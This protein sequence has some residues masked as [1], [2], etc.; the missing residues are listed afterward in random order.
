MFM[1]QMNADK[2]TQHELRKTKK[3]AEE[4]TNAETQH[5][6]LIYTQ[7]PLKPIG[8]ENNCELNNKNNVQSMQADS[9]VGTNS[10]IMN[11]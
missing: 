3:K 7:L 11:S 4:S 9:R 10:G 1:S 6:K 5:P 2:R 8:T